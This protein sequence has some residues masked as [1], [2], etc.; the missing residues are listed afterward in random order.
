[1]EVPFGG[2]VLVGF[3]GQMIDGAL[4]L[5]Y[6]V[7]CSTFLLGLGLSPAAASASVHTAELFTT[8]ASGLSHLSLKNVDRDLFRRLVGPGVVG[9]VC[10]AALASVLPGEAL[11]PVLSV[12]L[13]AMG[14]RLVVRVWGPP[15]APRPARGDRRLAFVGGF[16]D[17]AGGGGWGPIVTSTL[18]GRGVEPRR[19][20]GSV[21]LA[22]FF[23]ALASSVTFFGTLGLQPWRPV[24]GLVLGGLLAAPLAAWSVSRLPRRLTMALVGLV[25]C[26]LSLR[27]LFG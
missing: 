11:K 20:V 27:N 16:A 1:M 19:V 5:A 23:V 3:I 9:A 25:V 10:G 6:G 12:Y 13:A 8:A 17:A 4:G 21:N 14:L 22:E 7:S 24:C 2:L 26:A 15:P 18:L